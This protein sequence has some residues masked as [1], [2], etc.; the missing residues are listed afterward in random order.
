MEAIFIQNDG[1]EKMTNSE[2]QFETWWKIKNYGASSPHEL[3]AIRYSAK[4]AYLE[5]TRQTYLDCVKICRELIDFDEDDPG[6][7]FAEAIQ[8]RLKE[9]MP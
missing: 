5:A 7:S 4:A 6:V 9:L 8:A 2:E 1:G 3:L